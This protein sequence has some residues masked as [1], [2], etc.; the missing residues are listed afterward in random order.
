MVAQSFFSL[1]IGAGAWGY[2]ALM[3]SDVAKAKAVPIL[4]SYF[5]SLI[6]TLLLLSLSLSLVSPSLMLTHSFSQHSSVIKEHDHPFQSAEKKRRKT[7]PPSRPPKPSSPGES[8]GGFKSLDDIL[9]QSSIIEFFGGSSASSKNSEDAE[10]NGR[11]HKSP[12]N[13]NKSKI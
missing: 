3:D 7:E 13:K 1:L 9:S 11:K 10:D 12:N 6:T 5:F 8:G 2:V 4:F